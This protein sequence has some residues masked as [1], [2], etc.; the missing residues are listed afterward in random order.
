MQS[1]IAIIEEDEEDE[2]ARQEGISMGNEKKMD[3]SLQ[4]QK[5][6]I[7]DKLVGMNTNMRQFSSNVEDR[8]NKAYKEGNYNKKFGF[9]G[10]T[11][12]NMEE[13]WEKSSVK[14]SGALPGQMSTFEKLLHKDNKM[15]D[16]MQN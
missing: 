2:D 13:E 7:I 10:L 11:A 9:E 5:E 14:S 16:R 6:D 4:K 8:L 15:L 3:V 12:N 1:K